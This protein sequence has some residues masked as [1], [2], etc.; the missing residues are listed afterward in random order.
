MNFFRW[1]MV[2]LAL[3]T[4]AL[5]GPFFGA[6]PSASSATVWTPP[7]DRNYRSTREVERLQ[8]A[9]DGALLAQTSGG[10]WRLQSGRWS[11]TDAPLA[12]EPKVSW[13]GQSA[14]FDFDGLQ[15]GA[16]KI[17]MPPSSGTH[18]SALIERDRTLWASVFG[19]GIWQWDGAKWARVAPELPPDAREITA[20]ALGKD[21]VLWIGTR[22][23]GVW[24]ARAGKW[25][26][27]LQTGEP[28]AHNVQSLCSFRGALWASTLE[29]GLIVRDENGWKHVGKPMISSH[30]P[31][32]LVVFQDK[33]YLRH[34]N[35]KVDCFD[36]I[37]WSRDVFDKLPRKQV[38]SLAA[39]GDHLYLG[40]WGGWSAWDGQK[41]SHFL[42]LPQLQIVPLVQIVP[43]AKSGNLWLATENRG[44]FE[45]DARAQKLRHYDERDG[46]PDDW[47]TTVS[48]NGKRVYAGTFQG[49]IAWRD[50][51]ESR[52]HSSDWKTGVSAIA[53][54][55]RQSWVATRFGLYCG[56]ESGVLQPCEMR[57]SP[58][59]REIQALLTAPGGLW[60]GTRNGLLFRQSR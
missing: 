41:F 45:W 6:N 27:H 48:R 1:M 17:A 16:K 14:T 40:Q 8:I 13:R 22:R 35:E 30:A 4:M 18:I 2:P 34:S 31:R 32:Q 49:G 53:S 55:S 15:I 57:L 58:G 5:G 36:G 12:S 56:D 54:A 52:W 29:D 39:D 38:I 23:Q 9:P 21:G 20:M 43:D 44:L 26:Q 37:N 24:S 42:K 33:L 59:Q 50:D 46:L 47:I 25:T 7:A 11:E 51:G 60:I 28:F 3:L 10:N 19:D